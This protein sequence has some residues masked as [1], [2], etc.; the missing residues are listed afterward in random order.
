VNVSFV[1]DEEDL[2]PAVEA[3][4]RTV[5]TKVNEEAFA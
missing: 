4:H 5:L 1:I 3:L 2:R